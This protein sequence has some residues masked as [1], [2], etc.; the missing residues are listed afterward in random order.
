MSIRELFS[1]LNVP[2]AVE[3]EGDWALGA[4][5]A[6]LSSGRPF[7][8]GRHW[9]E[10]AARADRTWAVLS[11]RGTPIYG[12]PPEPAGLLRL[13]GASGNERSLELVV[14]PTWYWSFAGSNVADLLE[15]TT[16]TPGGVRADPLTVNIA[17]I[18][19]PSDARRLLVQQRA[20]GVRV[21]R[22]Q[23][24]ISAAGFVDREDHSRRSL[25]GLAWSAACREARE[26]TSI[27]LEPNSLRHLA[28][29]RAEQA[30]VPGLCG[31]ARVANVPGPAK[32]SG[33]DAFEV[34]GFEW[35]PW[36]PSAVLDR[37]R[38]DGG[39]SSWVPLGAAALVA[40][41]HADFGDAA[42]LQAWDAG[43]KP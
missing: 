32:T 5:R 14:Q 19:G 17:I 26:E 34:E 41:L 10:F 3:F 31:V 4:V 33:G 13:V 42:V 11:A 12:R 25:G 21:G 24:Q 27:Q 22:E 28:L 7:R 15:R 23:H 30:S 29:C 8:G 9:R 18:V 43:S 38:Q 40:A 36:E 39:W 1:K 35:W 20:A 6:R 2:V 37:V 16:V